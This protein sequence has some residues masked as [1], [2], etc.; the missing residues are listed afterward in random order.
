MIYIRVEDRK[1]NIFLFTAKELSRRKLY[2]IFA[3]KISS[4][5]STYELIKEGKS[6]TFKLVI[7]YVFRKK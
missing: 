3:I 1:P 5:L 2:H 4:F 6:P 7:E